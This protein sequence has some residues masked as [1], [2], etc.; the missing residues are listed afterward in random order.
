MTISGS[1]GCRGP[2]R[3]RARVTKALLRFGVGGPAAQGPRAGTRRAVG[4]SG[5]WDV[6]TRTARGNSGDR[7]APDRI[8]R[9]FDA[10]VPDRLRVPVMP[11]GHIRD[12]LLSSRSLAAIAPCPRS[13]QG[14]A[15]S[16]R[17]VWVGCIRSSWSSRSDIVIR[18]FDIRLAPQ[19]E[20][21]LVDG[22]SYTSRTPPCTSIV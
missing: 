10:D 8:E 5:R 14:Q 16:C 6:R 3:R 7:A 1:R 13:R 4:L 15:S 20:M 17:H 2:G 21:I 11:P 19:R 22:Y 12:G 9:Q 18:T